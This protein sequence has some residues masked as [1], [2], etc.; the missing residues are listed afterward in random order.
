M[1]AM[2]S[3]AGETVSAD[4]A[5]ESVAPS[6]LRDSNG[7]NGMHPMHTHTHTHMQC[8]SGIQW[9]SKLHH[10]LFSCLIPMHI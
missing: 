7:H 9:A 3:L 8:T 1:S 4:A 2:A 5:A 6:R 10:G